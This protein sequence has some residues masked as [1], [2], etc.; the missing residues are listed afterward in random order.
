[1]F[2]DSKIAGKYASGRTKT[3]CII[4]TLSSND[5]VKIA[6]NLKKC[7]FSLATDGS[8]DYEDVKMYPICVRYFDSDTG[9]VLSV[10]LSLTEC[11]EASTGENIF[12]LS[13]KELVGLDIPWE[14][15]ISFA[16]DNVSVMIGKHKGVAAFLC[17]KA[18][19]VHINGTV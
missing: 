18:P 17:K 10:L 6:D 11:S 4:D 9:H 8:T 3:S 7:P 16:T 5:K 12:K 14:N 15:L 19:A 1:M 2:P 13:E